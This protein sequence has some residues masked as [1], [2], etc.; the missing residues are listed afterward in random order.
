MGDD[1]TQVARTID[2][3]VE[4]IGSGGR[5]LRI[6]L[7][8]T[9]CLAVLAVSAPSVLRTRPPWSLD[10]TPTRR[11]AE[12]EYGRL[13]AFFEP[14]LGQDGS[15]A[16]FLSRGPGY[17]VAMA[18]DEIVLRNTRADS[19]ADGSRSMRMRFVGSL[20][21]PRI[22]G[23]GRLPGVVNHISGSDP[24]GW[25]TD[26]PTFAG[27]RYES[28]YPGID[29]VF[30]GAGSRPEYD[31]VVSPG[32][33]PRAIALAFP[34]ADALAIDDSGDLTFRLGGVTIR[35]LAPVIFQ[36]VAGVR[37]EVEGGFV[38]TDSGRIGFEVGPV[39]PTRPLIID[40]VIYSTFLGGESMDAGSRS[41]PTR[42]ATPTS[43]GSR[44]RPG[45]R[46]RPARPRGPRPRAPMSS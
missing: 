24:S 10:P 8:V 21:D 19:P 35:H 17:A 32:A 42:P 15:A 40:P 33:D 1:S 38:R 45:S 46:R 27:V 29:L 26:I 25:L 2:M 20:P 22:V 12:D 7:S 31:F 9:A 36:S 43:P 37:H 6:L 23:T 4:P 28:I 41:R 16:R 39:R 14:N 13:P 34:G 44:P 18:N 30:H 5:P 11:A 3:T